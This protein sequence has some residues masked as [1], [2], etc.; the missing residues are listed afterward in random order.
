MQRIA[1]AVARLGRSAHRRRNLS[2]PH[3][4]RRAAIGARRRA[5]ARGRSLRRVELLQVLQHDRVAAG[6][7]G[8]ARATPPR[9]RKARAEPL[10]LA[11]DRL[12]ARRAR[13]L[14]AGDAGA[15]RG[16]PACIPRP[17][18]FPGAG[19]ARA[20][21]RHSG[22][23]DRRASS[24]TRTARASAADSQAFCRDAARRRRRRDHAGRRL[25]PPPRRGARALRVHDRDGEARR[26]AS[27][28]CGGS[29]GRR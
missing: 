12:A 22:D 16:A 25:R 23:A 9:P 14:P 6:L 1:A 13:V 15:A 19:A 29:F 24:S 10:H 28:A 3:L 4:R 5:R 20:G 8:R 18:R 26:T 27:S 11:A 2:R 21:L 17:P 7:A